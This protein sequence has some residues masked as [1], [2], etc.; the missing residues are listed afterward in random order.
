MYALQDLA[1]SVFHVVAVYYDCDKKLAE[2]QAVEL[3]MY[4]RRIT[5]IKVKK[6]PRP[7]V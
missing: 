7:H 1:R 2:H 6:D 4:G 5:V 3:N